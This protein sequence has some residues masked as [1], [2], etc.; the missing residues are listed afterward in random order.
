MPTT[1][2]HK[3][4]A[5]FAI[6]RDKFSSLKRSAIGDALIFVSPVGVLEYLAVKENSIYRVKYIPV[7]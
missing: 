4:C 3:C 2:R 5:G 6:C 7:P 1:M